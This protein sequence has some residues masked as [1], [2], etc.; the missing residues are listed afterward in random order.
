MYMYAKCFFC[1]KYNLVY[2]KVG[3]EIY[4]KVCNHKVNTEI[5]NL[6]SPPS[7]Y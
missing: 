7:Q 1:G 5:E 2:E 4:C 6:T 3:Q